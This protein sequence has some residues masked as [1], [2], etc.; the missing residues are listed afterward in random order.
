MTE[1]TM[2]IQQLGAQVKAKYPAYGQYSDEEVGKRTLA[3]YPV[4]QSRIA[5]AP[6]PAPSAFGN[7][8]KD[9]ETAQKYGSTFTPSTENP[10][11]LGEGL[12]TLGNMPKSAFNFVKGAINFLNPV[13]IAGDIA[14]I[15]GA[16][17]ELVKETGGVGPALKAFGGNLPSATYETL[18][19]E[20]GKGLIQAGKGVFTKNEAD[21][22]QGLETAQRVITAD[23]VGQIAPFLIAGRAV[24][25]KAGVGAQFDTAVSKVARPVTKTAGAFGAGAKSFVGG[26]TKFAVGQATG[27][28]PET[29][30]QITKTPGAFTK[31]AMSQI[32]R[33]S[34]GREVQS[35]LNKK[36]EVLSETGEA[37]AP[38][39]E[40]A[41]S[42]KVAPTWLESN[43]RDLT[44]LDIKKGKVTTTGAAKLRDASD[45]RAIQHIYDLWQPVFKKGAMTANEFLNF[46][47]DLA[48]L[49]KF[50]RQIGKSQPLEGVTKIARDRFNEAYRPQLEGLE[51]LDQEFSG[52]IAELRRLSKN[53]VDKDGNLTEAAI[54]RI[55]N[56]TGKGKDI[57]L[58][59]LEETV[60]GIT[61]KIKVL[62]AVEDVQHASGI[63]VGTYGRAAVTGGAFFL[64]GPI[65]AIITAVL[66]SPELAVPL[67]RRYGLIK[68]SSA[69]NA[70]VN[71]LRS[72][73]TTI[74]QLPNKPPAVL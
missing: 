47:A 35:V 52:Q 28:Q 55:A 20:A 39:R 44:G 65:Q 37:Y 4:Y 59:R 27:L 51:K 25:G 14:Q 73:A 67:L 60:P 19:P 24:A 66:T 26:G 72:G 1:A 71:A 29:I 33:G 15:P 49:S 31:P 38:I 63:K 32:E 61:Q 46:R 18:V 8:A 13:R 54:N 2:T 64:G 16:F 42:V 40:G 12:K 30:S 70:V 10:S 22:T 7:R 36:A 62:K 50:E 6:A 68:N 53:L 3:K 48:K 21:I 5:E 11:A 17:K 74:N 69:V 57:L 56:A 43:L 41:S 23:P 9:I 45:V 34:L 58:D